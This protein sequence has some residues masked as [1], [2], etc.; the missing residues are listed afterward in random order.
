MSPKSPKFCPYCGHR[1]SPA[2]ACDG[3]TRLRCSQCNFT[4]Y[5]DPKVAVGAVVRDSHG[6]VLLIQRDIDPGRGLWTFPGGYVDR[7]ENPPEAARRELL[8]ETGVEVKLETLQ[9]VYRAPESP[10]L[11]LV[12][13]ALLVKGTARPLHECRDCG[14]FSDKDVPWE[15]LAFSTTSQALRDYWSPAGNS[16]P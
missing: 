13:R 10:V 4:H 14:F 1:L 3:T 16:A 5:E 8:E 15:K 7:Y 12:Y 6:S 11:L 9:G 2:P